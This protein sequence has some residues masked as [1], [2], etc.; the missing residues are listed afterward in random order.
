MLPNTA[1]LIQASAVNAPLGL[2]DESNNVAARWLDPLKFTAVSVLLA[3]A[4]GAWWD[5]SLM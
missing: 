2:I 1:G 5:G 3:N 4:P